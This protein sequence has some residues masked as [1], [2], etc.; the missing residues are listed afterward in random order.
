MLQARDDEQQVLIDEAHFEARSLVEE[1]RDVVDRIA[2]TLLAKETIERE[3]I[4][5][6]LARDEVDL[7]A[8]Q[9]SVAPPQNGRARRSVAPPNGAVPAP[10]RSQP[11]EPGRP[12]AFS[13]L[14]ADVRRDR[15]RRRGCR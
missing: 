10:A 3:E 13:R 12:A 15:P 8:P 6:I 7:P 14:P 9:E 11:Q 5:S 2:E 1:N 4:E